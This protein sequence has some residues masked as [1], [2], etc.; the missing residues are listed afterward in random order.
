MASW[1]GRRRL[2]PG[3]QA[4]VRCLIQNPPRFPGMGP[5][6]YAPGRTA[7]AEMVPVFRHLQS[8]ANLA[9]TNLSVWLKPAESRFGRP[10][11]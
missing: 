7:R 8:S 6:P 5:V 4:G 11:P 10:W 1:T 9:L 3:I 2:G